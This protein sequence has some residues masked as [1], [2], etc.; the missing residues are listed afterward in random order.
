[1]TI[2]KL[3][4]E[5]DEANWLYENREG[6]LEAFHEAAQEGRVQH[7]TLNLYGNSKYADSTSF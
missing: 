7:G 3:E 2:P 1:M 5:A 4:N 6:L